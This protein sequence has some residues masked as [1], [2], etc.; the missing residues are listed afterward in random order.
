MNTALTILFLLLPAFPDFTG[1]WQ[2][3]SPVPP[4]VSDPPDSTSRYMSDTEL[5]KQVALLKTISDPVTR[6]R[7]VTDIGNSYNK[8][9]FTVL[10][11]YL[12]EEEDPS[13]RADIISTLA[14]LPVRKK[15]PEDLP[16]IRI[17]W[18]SVDPAQ[19]EN[20]AKSSCLPE[21]MA[22]KRFLSGEK[23]LGHTEIRL[24]DEFTAM[25]QKYFKLRNADTA[26]SI[27]QL[28]QVIDTHELPL[29]RLEAIRSLSAQKKLSPTAVKKL[30]K[31]ITEDYVRIQL[32]RGR[33]GSKWQFDHDS[34]RSAAYM[35]LLE[36]AREP[37]AARALK[38]IEPKLNKVLAKGKNP[39]LQEYV[40]QIRLAVKGKKVV[41]SPLPQRGSNRTFRFKE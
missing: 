4:I 22:A 14:N 10:D 31:I 11:A 16:S 12:A 21:K 8:N 41:P 36:H 33:G 32:G 39:L 9:V 3:E 15:Q 28:E 6:S 30:Q 20:S 17:D 40:R 35:A 5:Q 29:I 7:I 26:E 25:Q 23:F 27:K 19:Y 38:T 13:V 34:V 37:E 2:A 24:P 18:K 1:A